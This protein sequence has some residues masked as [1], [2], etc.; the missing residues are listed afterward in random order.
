MPTVTINHS[1]RRGL[2]SHEPLPDAVSGNEA[3]AFTEYFNIGIFSVLGNGA[4]GL[5]I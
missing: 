2:P 3:Q 5:T 4:Y 1:Q